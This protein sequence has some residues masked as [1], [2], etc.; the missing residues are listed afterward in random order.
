[1]LEH[2]ITYHDIDALIFERQTIGIES[3]LA[4]ASSSLHLLHRG[5]FSHVHFSGTYRL[6]ATVRI[7]PFLNRL[8]HQMTI[9]AAEVEH[10]GIAANWRAE[11]GQNL[12][13]YGESGGHFFYG[14][15][16]NADETL[17]KACALANCTPGPMAVQFRAPRSRDMVHTVR[18][19]ALRPLAYKAANSQLPTT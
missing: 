3:Y 17:P 16:P 6:L 11:V 2:L 4:K 19:R 10:G 1:M 15:S 12:A 14:E 8:L 7:E 5:R 9:P 18:R 13:E